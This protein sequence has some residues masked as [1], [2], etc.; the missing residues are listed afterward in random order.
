[1]HIEK[2]FSKK[3]KREVWWP[4]EDIKCWSYLNKKVPIELPYRVS[5]LCKKRNNVIQAGGNAGL[6]PLIYSELFKNV[7]TFEPQYINYEC[8]EKNLHNITNVIYKNQA[9]GS[10]E[11]LISLEIS[12]NHKKNFGTFHIADQCQH[13]KNNIL[14]VTVDSLNIDV[15]L[16]H[17]DLEGFEGPALVGSKNTIIKNKPLIV[18]ETNGSG[19]SYGWPQERIDNFLYG[20]GYKEI[21]KGHDTIYEYQR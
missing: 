3:L 1:M 15:D 13:D 17:F 16:I 19:D 18:L 12:K 6:Y 7:Y 21:E 20:L 11:K 10:E 9:L 14:M 5:K 8:L 2:R 4:V